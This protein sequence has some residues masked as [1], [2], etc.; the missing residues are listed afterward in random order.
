MQIM[1]FEEIWSE[2]K[3]GID[4]LTEKISNDKSINK[5]HFFDKKG[6]VCHQ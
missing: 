6:N 1:S 2:L 3:A 5:N 4:L